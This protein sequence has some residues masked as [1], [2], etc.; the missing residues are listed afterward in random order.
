[1]TKEIISN[2]VPI[3]IEESAK[4]KTGH[5]LTSIKSMTYRKITLSIRLASAPDII[6]IKPRFKIKLPKNLSFLIA[7]KRIAP[8]INIAITDTAIKNQ[9]LFLKSPNAA[10]V[11]FIN[12]KCNTFFI[13]GMDWPGDNLEETTALET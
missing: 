1:L 12:V 8:I 9:M 2:A 11:F 5:I 6:R 7:F 3:V 4:L 13:I 10:P